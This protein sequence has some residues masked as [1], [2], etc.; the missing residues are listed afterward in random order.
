MSLTEY[1]SVF[2]AIIVG[3]AVTDLL[4]SLHGL[5]RAGRRVKWD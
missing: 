3:L 2:S 4:A 5:I 1:V